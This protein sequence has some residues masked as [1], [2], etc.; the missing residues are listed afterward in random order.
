MESRYSF[1]KFDINQR[2]YKNVA[3]SSSENL[4][5]TPANGQQFVIIRAGADSSSTPDTNVCIVWDPGGGSQEIILST[6]RDAAHENINKTFTGDGS[7]VLRIML[8][9]DLTETSYLGGYVQG[10]LI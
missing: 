9:N 1:Y 7:K 4:D 5:W 8:V 3:A 10:E 2:M 6:Y